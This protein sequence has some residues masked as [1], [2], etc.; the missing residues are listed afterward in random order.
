MSYKQ[1]FNPIDLVE[2]RRQ[3]RSGILKVFISRNCIYIKDSENDECVMICK[4]KVG[5]QE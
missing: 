5:E 4:M 2:L 3:I 1:S